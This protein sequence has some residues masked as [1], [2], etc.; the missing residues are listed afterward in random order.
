MA[1]Y[2]W[3]DGGVKEFGSDYP[4]ATQKLRSKTKMLDPSKEYMTEAGVRMDLFPDWGFDG[5][6]TGQ[7]AGSSSDCVLKPVCAV[8]D[9]I[10]RK[11]ENYL[12]MCEVYNADGTPH[13]TNQR[14]RLVKLHE[15]HAAQ[16]P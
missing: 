1:E 12:V 11:G 3:L 15:T 2:I 4:N 8:P 16:K 5:S 14:A 10:R 7:A 6:S 9:P 13:S